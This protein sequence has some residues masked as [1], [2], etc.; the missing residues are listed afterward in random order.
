MLGAGLTLQSLGN[1]FAVKIVNLDSEAGKYD[2]APGDEI[3]S[4]LV[5]TERISRYWFAVLALLLPAGIVLLQL[6]RRMPKL[7]AV[8]AGEPAGL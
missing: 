5:P 4:V 7:V 1:R 3:V 2:L 8:S 6:R